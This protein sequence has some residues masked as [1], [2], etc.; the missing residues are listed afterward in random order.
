MIARPELTIGVEEEYQVVDPESRE[1][2]SVITHFRKQNQLEIYDREITSELHQSMVE[3][4]T[5]VCRTAD[6]IMSD[7]RQQRR[8]I[9]DLARDRSW[10]IAAASTHPFSH[11]ETQDIS[12]Y[13]RYQALT[14]EYQIV[15]RRMLIW[16]M[17]VHIGISDREVLIDV[18][19]IT[20]Y[21]LPHVLALSA[22]SPFWSG[23]PTGMKSY[24]THIADDFPRSGMP[25]IFRS[26]H[27]YNA[28]A[29]TLIRTNCISDT[30]KIWWNLRPHHTFPTLEFRMSDICPRITE[31]VAIAALLQALV[32]WVWRL[33]TRNLSFHFYSKDLINEN[34]WRASLYGLDGRFADLG[35]RREIPVRTAIRDLLSMLDEEITELEIRPHIEVIHR[36]LEEGSSAD[37]QLAVYQETGDLRQVVDHLIE[38][39]G[40]DLEA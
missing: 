6:E 23:I 15:A 14:E 36:I 29:E 1:L 9:R 25:D 18:M 8:Y 30:S 12:P 10:Q 4:G 39:T 31:G 13:E 19:N 3:L 22:S 7:L 33:R 35:T 21:F 5:R 24:R 2:Q 40:M 32:L 11:W 17:H 28:M 27:E 37:R 16:G 38:E 20:R 34:K 26:W